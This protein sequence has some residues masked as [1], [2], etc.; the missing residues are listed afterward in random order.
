MPILQRGLGEGFRGRSAGVRHADVELSVLL[1]RVRNEP[2]DLVVVGDIE[3]A[4]HDPRAGSAADLLGGFDQGRFSAR[5]QCQPGS[6]F[7]KPHRHGFS[8]AL[9]GGGDDGNAFFESKVHGITPAGTRR[10]S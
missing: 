5:T 6:L 1:H 3:G 2:E 10:L 7:G 9:A 4:R 8:Q